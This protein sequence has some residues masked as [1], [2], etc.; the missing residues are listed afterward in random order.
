M[1]LATLWL[2]PVFW[3]YHFAAVTPALAV[4]C[5]RRVSQ[6]VVAW[7]GTALWLVTLAT[8][9]WRLARAFGATLWLTFALGAL[10]VW[11]KDEEG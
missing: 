7:G 5:R 2:S 9:G 8:F 4:I 10:L 11:E 3:G 6:P 1:A